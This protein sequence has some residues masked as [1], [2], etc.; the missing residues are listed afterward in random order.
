MTCGEIHDFNIDELH[1][2]TSALKKLKQQ[3]RI[4][5]SNLKPLREQRKTLKN[6]I[7][8]AKAHSID[9]IGKRPTKIGYLEGSLTKLNNKMKPLERQLK[10][11]RDNQQDKKR[12][13]NDIITFP[14]TIGKNKYTLQIKE[15]DI[16]EA[17]AET[18]QSNRAYKIS[19]TILAGKNDSKKAIDIIVMF[20]QK[21][22]YAV[23]Y[24]KNLSLDDHALLVKEHYYKKTNK[25]KKLRR[26][27]ELFEKMENNELCDRTPIPEDVRLFVWRR[28]NGKCVKCGSKT[29]LEFDHIIPVSKGGSNTERNIQILCEHCNRQ[30]SNKI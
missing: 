2:Q 19:Y 13:I 11:N 12:R 22:L 29:N 17:A 25:F 10:L 6:N 14:L 16:N 23:D 8:S 26:E 7:K 15:T 27:I 30:K 3:E 9:A 21:R 5:T 20:F 18:K 4:L 24:D 1:K 28:D